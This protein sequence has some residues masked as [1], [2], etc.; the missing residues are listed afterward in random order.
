MAWLHACPL[1][2]VKSWQK[3]SHMGYKSWDLGHRLVICL[4]GVM[5]RVQGQPVDLKSGECLGLLWSKAEAPSLEKLTQTVPIGSW[6]T[7]GVLCSGAVVGGK[8]WGSVSRANKMV[9]WG[10]STLLA[11]GADIGISIKSYR[12]F[13]RGTARKRAPELFHQG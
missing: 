10:A 2:P 11:Q 1:I 9:E 6:G 7:D 5:V 13:C 8:D 12:K 3:I 4:G